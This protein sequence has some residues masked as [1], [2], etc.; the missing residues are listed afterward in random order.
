MFKKKK[1]I[2]SQKIFSKKKITIKEQTRTKRIRDLSINK[3]SCRTRIDK[4]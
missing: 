4:I 2:I 1:T 3:K